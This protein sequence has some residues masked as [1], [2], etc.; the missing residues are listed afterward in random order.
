M[1]YLGIDFG[2]KRVGLA[3]SSPSGSAFPLKTINRTTR[4]DLFDQILTV[5]K[6]E[7]IDALVIGIPLDPGN[8][9]SLTSRQ[10]YNFKE[11]LH[12]RVDIPIYTM[13]EAYTSIEARS[14]LAQN[15][16]N[17]YRMKNNIDKVAA[18]LI[19]ESFLNQNSS[20]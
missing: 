13:N 16:M 15:K 14:I 5:I 19:L 7:K 11:S 1:R 4:E 3:V 9:N 2:I 8:E 20:E 12:R 18:M 6:E 17:K 10:V